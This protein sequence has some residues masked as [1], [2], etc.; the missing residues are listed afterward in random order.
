MD[1]IQKAVSHQLLDGDRFPGVR[2]T[3]S[4]R[5]E[6]FLARGRIKMRTELSLGAERIVIYGQCRQERASTIHTYVEGFS[7]LR[8]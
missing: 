2:S 6:C 7:G 4:G 5:K 8:P 1:G 3:D